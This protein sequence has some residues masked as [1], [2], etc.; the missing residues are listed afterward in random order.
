MHRL[1]R[2]D[3][4]SIILM[5]SL[6]PPAETSPSKFLK[7]FLPGAL[8]RNLLM[9]AAKQRHRK[10]HIDLET[11][12]VVGHSL[13]ISAG[14]IASA[15]LATHGYGVLGATVPIAGTSAIAAW[16]AH[17]GLFK[18]LRRLLTMA[19]AVRAGDL[20][21]R[22]AIDREDEMGRLAC[23]M[24]AM[25]DQLQAAKRASEAHIASLEQLR[26]SDRVAT[27]GLLASSVAH[28]LGNP[29]NVIELR[30]QLI[31]SGD[32][33][34]LHQ[35]QQNALVIVEQT[36]RMTRI[37]NEILSFVRTQPA[38]IT[39]LNL[40]EVLR[41]AIALSEHTSKKHRT[42]VRLDTSQAAIE[43]DGDADKL[44]QVIVNLVVNGVQAM[45]GG[46]TLRVST[47]EELRPPVGDPDG[48]HRRYVCVDEGLGI[49]ADVVARIFEPFFSTKGAVGGT[50]LGL[51]VAQGIAQEHEGWISVKS[52]IGRG[53]SFK[54]HL[55]ANGLKGHG[56]HAE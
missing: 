28:E 32:T 12:Y 24:D 17:R 50:G 40:V 54:V 29:L 39:R 13:L 27:L 46:G 10:A 31:S 8:A 6:S 53:S 56:G 16:L 14:C 35:A 52:Q 21:M 25:C 43:I 44:L 11:K 49:P 26:H 7:S 23:E 37:I 20:S 9:P 30:A 41:K 22:L 2:I 15:V 4:S 3:V 34:T 33:A 18:P 36:R 47:G 55:P 42:H 5:G 1:G 19:K 48:A 45:P 38:N 51:S